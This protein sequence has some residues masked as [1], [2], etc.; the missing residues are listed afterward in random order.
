MQISKIKQ[1]LFFFFISVI[2]VNAQTP[3]ANQAMTLEQC[4]DYALKNN[5]QINEINFLN[6][7]QRYRLNLAA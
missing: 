4:I 1:L 7:V 3:V 5:I 6:H 2:T